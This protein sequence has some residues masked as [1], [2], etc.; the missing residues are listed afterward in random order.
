M[1]RRKQKDEHS[2]GYKD[3]YQVGYWLCEDYSVQSEK[4]LHYENCWQKYKALSADRQDHGLE[5]FSHALKGKVKDKH[6]SDERR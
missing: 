2:G 4:F 6:Y 1:Q 3:C 5:A